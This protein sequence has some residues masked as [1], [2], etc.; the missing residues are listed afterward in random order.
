MCGL[1]L[2]ID[3]DEEA[4]NYSKSLNR[5]GIS[6]ILQADL[7]V[8]EL[9]AYSLKFLKRHPTLDNQGASLCEL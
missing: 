3:I 4:C 8:S 1:Q 9:L 2:H 7:D 6:A 5:V